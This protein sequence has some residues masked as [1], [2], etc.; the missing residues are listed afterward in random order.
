MLRLFTALDEHREQRHPLQ[1]EGMYCPRCGQGLQAT[2][3]CR[4]TVDRAALERA[5]RAP[6]DIRA[7]DLG[8]SFGVVEAGV[9]ALVRLLSDPPGLSAP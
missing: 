3:A 9:S 5:F 4:T 8:G 6:T 2:V 1:R 7:L